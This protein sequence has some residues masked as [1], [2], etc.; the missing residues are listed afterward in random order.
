V[1]GLKS[2]CKNPPCTDLVPD[3]LRVAQDAVP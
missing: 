1:Q 3:G 2:V